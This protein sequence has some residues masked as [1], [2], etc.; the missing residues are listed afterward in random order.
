M[1]SSYSTDKGLESRLYKE[2]KKLNSRK[3]NNSI[4][5]WANELKRQFSEEEIQIVNNHVKTYSISLA[6]KMH[7]KANSDF[8]SF[9]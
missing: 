2:L 6:I 4:N 5:K 8:P 9:Q 1:F 7:I 3:T